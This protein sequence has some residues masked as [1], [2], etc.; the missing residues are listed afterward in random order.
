LGTPLANGLEAAAHL[1]DV[2]GRTVITLI[3]DGGESCGGDPCAVARTIKQSRPRLLA[4][5]IDI[6]GQGGAACVA[7]AT[8]GRVFTPSKMEDFLSSIERATAGCQ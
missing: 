3:S 7:E 6:S 5:V 1:E 4:N 8:G 2:S